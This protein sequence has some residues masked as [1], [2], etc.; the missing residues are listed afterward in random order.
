MNYDITHPVD[1]VEITSEYGW[2]RLEG[3]DNFHYGIDYRGKKGAFCYAIADGVVGISKLNNGGGGYGE[4]IFIDHDGFASGYAHL[5]KRKVTVGQEVKKGDLIGFIGDTGH[6]F[7]AHLHFE[8]SSMNTWDPDFF[9]DKFHYIDQNGKNK[10]VPK[11][12]LDPSKFFL[13]HMQQDSDVMA[14][15]KQIVELETIISNIH[16]ISERT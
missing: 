2:R 12:C 10:P 3:A 14:L 7:G 5:D 11:R 1:V 16:T 8:I 15:E 6:A 9:A 13:Q 4:Y